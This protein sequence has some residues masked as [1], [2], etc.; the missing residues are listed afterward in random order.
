M[1]YLFIVVA[2][3]GALLEA[4]PRGVPM[5][6]GRIVGGEPTSI[7][8][9]PYQ[10]SLQYLSFHICGAVVISENYVV[11]AAHCTYTYALIVISSCFS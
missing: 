4:A 11:T 8:E 6:D 10:A 5:L 3:L 2:C 1:F 7:E 9:Y